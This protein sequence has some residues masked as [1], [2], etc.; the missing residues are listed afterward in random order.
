MY[1]ANYQYS[2]FCSIS[3]A[4]IEISFETV[5]NYLNFELL[6]YRQMHLSGSYIG[7]LSIC[8]THL[9]GFITCFH[10]LPSSLG[11]KHQYFFSGSWW[12]RWYMAFKKEEDIAALEST[13]GLNVRIEIY[14]HTIKSYSI[15]SKLMHMN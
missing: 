8:Q 9:L 11:G 12:M 15:T 2:I 4:R 7:D 6:V 10:G 13:F 1:L 14:R 5:E 3:K